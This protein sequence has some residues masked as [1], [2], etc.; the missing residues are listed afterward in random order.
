MV[1]KHRDRR[2]S[3]NP[4]AGREEL[5]TPL[6]RLDAVVVDQIF[7]GH[8]ERDGATMLASRYRGG[9]WQKRPDRLALWVT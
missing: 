6:I 5:I 9:L 7:G 2:N 3:A 1:L 8:V 4:Y